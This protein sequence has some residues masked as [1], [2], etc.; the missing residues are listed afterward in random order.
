[1]LFSVCVLLFFVRCGICVPVPPPVEEVPTSF[2]PLE[3]VSDLG[4]LERYKSLGLVETAV[5]TSQ[6]F[7]NV[8]PDARAF[9]GTP[10]LSAG[11]GAMAGAGAGAGLMRGMN[12]KGEIGTG[13][14]RQTVTSSQTEMTDMKDGVTGP[15]AGIA[16]GATGVTGR[17]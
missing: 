12:K 2:V 1:M 7:S 14:V 10:Q 15:A 11:A 16:G 8:H 17:R 5:A 6:P 13:S 3:S 9:P 4:R